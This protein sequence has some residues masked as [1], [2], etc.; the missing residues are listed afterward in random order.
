MRSGQARPC[1]SDRSIDLKKDGVPSGKGLALR[2]PDIKRGMRRR[3]QKVAAFP[4]R[5][6]FRPGMYTEAS[7]SW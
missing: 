7:P 1:A 6:M 4:S 3:A 2:I 5:A